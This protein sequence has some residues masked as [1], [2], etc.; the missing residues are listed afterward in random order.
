MGILIEQSENEIPMLPFYVYV[1]LDPSN[2]AVFYVGKGQGTRVKHHTS[3]TRTQVRQG[4]ES[5]CLKTNKIK[6]IIVT[7]QEPKEIVVARFETEAEAYAVEAT[8][9]QWV[10]GFDNLT[11]KVRGHG[12]DYIRKLDNLNELPGLDVPDAIRRN[13]NSYRDSKVLALVEAGAF[14]FQNELI[15]YLKSKNFHLR[16]FSEKPDRQYDPGTSNGVLGIFVRIDEIDFILSFSK[17]CIVSVI[18]ANTQHSRTDAAKA[19]LKQIEN[20]LGSNFYCG[21]PKNIKIQGEGRYRTFSVKPSFGPDKLYELATMLED[22]KT[23]Y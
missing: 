13:D 12:S 9:I 22:F 6:E 19:Q 15:E 11:N 10:Y 7:G 23:K 4:F 20:R 17:K 5:E 2:N 21:A 14:D 18:V 16:D 1:L 8:L 3:L